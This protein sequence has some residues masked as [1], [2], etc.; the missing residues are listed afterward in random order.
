MKGARQNAKLELAAARSAVTRAN[1]TLAL[2]QNSGTPEQ[3]E[4]A[5]KAFRAA[6]RTEKLARLLCGLLRDASV[7][8]STRS[9]GENQGSAP[10]EVANG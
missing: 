4:V 7:E 10:Q 3:I 2:V 9:D 1:L 5:H 6:I 8:N